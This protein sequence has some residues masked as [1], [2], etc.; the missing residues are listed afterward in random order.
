MDGNRNYEKQYLQAVRQKNNLRIKVII[1]LIAT[2]GAFAL[3]FF[4]NW[5]GSPILSAV[6]CVIVG[7]V[8]LK[9]LKQG[10]LSLFSKQPHMSAFGAAAILFTLIQLI[11]TIVSKE[12]QTACFAWAVF[13]FLFISYLLKYCYIRLFI[14][15]IQFVRDKDLFS[16]QTVDADLK[17]RYINKVC[18]VT[19]V[20]EFPEITDRIYS[21]DPMEKH[22][23]PFVQ[24]AIGACVVLGLI[25]LWLQGPAVMFATF[26][27]LTCLC[28][29][30]P[31]QTAFLIPYIRTQKQL[32]QEGSILFGRYSINHLRQTQTLLIEDNELFP[33]NQV[34]LENI[35]FTDKPHMAKALEY[36]VVLLNEISSPLAESVFKM[37]HFSKENLSAI[38]ALRSIQNYGLVG[39]INDDEVHMGNRNLLLS[40]GITPLSQDK[41]TELAAH[42][43]SV[44]YLAINKKLVLVLAANYSVNPTL[45]QKTEELGDF[46][47]LVESLD[48][49]IN[50]YM[51]SRCYNI[52]DINIMVTDSEETKILY[53]AHKKMEKKEPD[54]VMITTK[55]ALGALKSILW[56]KKLVPI[57]ASCSFI[58]KFSIYIGLLLTEAAFLT[59]PG[60]V[61]PLWLVLYTLLW[62]I[63]AYIISI[64]IH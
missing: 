62:T 8:C 31:G 51:I 30:I 24:I 43:K 3:S 23:Y 32:Q 7:I 18:M 28:A 47:I 4:P 35:L 53:T 33:P 48:F 19:P 12:N 41:E 22:S 55:S 25:S 45:K 49:N 37:C 15:N 13:L 16:V 5:I 50:E 60:L 21:G 61:T 58:K 64:H 36:A 17:K 1:T 40:Y 20:R 56:T 10:I 26:S 39:I 9:E 11:W 6:L 29:G 57:S 59:V 42:G 63:T 34:T 54:P 52:P 46:N 2:G 14:T 38:S 27:A 44:T